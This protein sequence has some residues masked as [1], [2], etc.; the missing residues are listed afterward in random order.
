MLTAK[1]AGGK[2]LAQLYCAE[3][4]QCQESVDLHKKAGDTFG[5]P[6]VYS[7][8][9]AATA[10]NYTAQCIA[11]Q[12]AGADAL[13]IGHSG[14]VVMKVAADCDRQGYKPIYIT[15]GTGFVM[16]EASAPGLS[17][18]LWSSYPILPFWGK[19]AQ[20]KEMK[21]AV[22]KYSP[23]TWNDPNFSEYAAQAWTGGKLIEAAV[24]KSG[25]AAKDDVTA[26]DIKTALDSMKD[27]TLGGWSPALTFTAGKPHSVDCWYTGRV[28][29]S[30]P[31]LVERRQVDLQEARHGIA[32]RDHVRA[33]A[34]LA[35]R[36]PARH[37]RVVHPESRGLAL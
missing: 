10:P 26:A 20:V 36:A 22:D 34:R 19:S 2:K 3:A 18:S 1:Q 31:K 35:G 11:A 5:V 14:S 37:P 24:E 28:Q 33:G 29:K 7:A 17:E 4:P 27:E 9:I 21:K 13:F 23:G 30:T 16:P 15:Q 12:Q 32:R 6:L 25:V 8:S